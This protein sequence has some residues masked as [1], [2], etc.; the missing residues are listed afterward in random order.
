MSI[1]LASDARRDGSVA[2]QHGGGVTELI[3][4]ARDICSA[5]KQYHRDRC[6]AVRRRVRVRGRMPNPDF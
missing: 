2:G 4:V 3:A 1:A 5:V 6:V